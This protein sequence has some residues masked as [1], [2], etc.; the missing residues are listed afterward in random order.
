M[1]IMSKKTI[2]SFTTIVTIGTMLL[3]AKNGNKPK[4]NKP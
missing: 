3:I 4:D 1:K 2:F